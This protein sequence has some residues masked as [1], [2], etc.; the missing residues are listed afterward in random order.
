MAMS[1]TPEHDVEMGE[2]PMKTTLSAAVCALTVSVGSAFAAKPPTD[3]SGVNV[4]R[5]MQAFLEKNN[6][7]LRMGGDPPITPGMPGLAATPESGSARIPNPWLSPFTWN[8]NIG[9]GGG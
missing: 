9:G 8:P 4:T 6:T 3:L 1:L 5:S 7:N 2:K